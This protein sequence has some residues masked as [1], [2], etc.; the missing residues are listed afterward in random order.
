MR[1]AQ[2]GSHS[3]DTASFCAG[4]GVKLGEATALDL[5]FLGGE[6]TLEAVQESEML[7]RRHG[8][9]SLQPVNPPLV[10][11]EFDLQVAEIASA[12]D[13]AI[14]LDATRAAAKL[15]AKR[16]KVARGGSPRVSPQGQLRVGVQTARSWWLPSLSEAE[17]LGAWHGS[18]LTSSRP[19]AA[20]PSR[21]ASS[22]PRSSFG[23]WARRGMPRRPVTLRELR[24][25]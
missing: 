6:S 19:A 18:A 20:W 13:R 12:P 15:A 22:A 5:S 23:R 4:C 2:C 24:F 16:G 14:A 1:C 21:S 9:R 10:A 17:A 7:V 8:F 25:A 11:A 3:P